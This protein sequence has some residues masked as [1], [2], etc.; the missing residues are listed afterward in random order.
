MVVISLGLV[1]LVLVAHGRVVETSTF[2]FV[3]FSTGEDAIAARTQLDKMDFQG[4]LL[5]ILQARA[6]P[7]TTSAAG[8]SGA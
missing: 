7:T 6:P 8:S 1:P 3:S 4:R 2:A 5:H